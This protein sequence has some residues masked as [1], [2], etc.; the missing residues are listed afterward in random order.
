MTSGDQA[1]TERPTTGPGSVYT[2]GQTTTP[3][4]RIKAPMPRWQILLL[5][6]VLLW[7]VA[8]MLLTAY[9]SS[10]DGNGRNGELLGWGIAL[11]VVGQTLIIPGLVGWVL[12]ATGSS[13]VTPTQSS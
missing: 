9:P 2:A 7:V 13:G 6:G 3:G 12:R 11:A 8:V 4:V 10:S 5:A 1:A